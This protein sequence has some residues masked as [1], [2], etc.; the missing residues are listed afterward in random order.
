MMH[1]EEMGK[2]LPKSC[3]NLCAFISDTCNWIVRI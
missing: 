3:N 2:R 1:S